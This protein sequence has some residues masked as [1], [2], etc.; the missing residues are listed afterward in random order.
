MS[1]EDLRDLAPLNRKEE[2]NKSR[3][4]FAFLFVLKGFLDVFAEMRAAQFC[5]VFFNRFIQCLN[6]SLYL[7]CPRRALTQRESERRVGP[8]GVGLRQPRAHLRLFF[9][10]PAPLTVFHLTHAAHLPPACQRLHIRAS[11]PSSRRP[12][13][14]SS[15]PPA[16]AAAAAANRQ[17]P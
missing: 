3:I 8:S 4:V 6:F 14:T 7:A 13:S 2:C 12:V 11:P 1:H 10:L 17:H 15:S 16:A 5:F 9:R